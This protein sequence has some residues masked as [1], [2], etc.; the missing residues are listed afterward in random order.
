MGNNYS[1]IPDID[2]NEKAV[3]VCDY[4]TQHSAVIFDQELYLTVFISEVMGNGAPLEANAK[5][6][7]IYRHPCIVKYITSWQLNSKFH[8]AVEEVTPLSRVL[9]KLDFLQISIGLHSILKALDFLHSNRVSHNNVCMSSIYV[10]KEGDWK[11]GGMEY[12]CNYTDLNCDYLNKIENNREYSD[13]VGD[14]RRKD[15]VDLYAFGSLA[16]D[17]LKSITDDVV[18]IFIDFCK[19]NLLNADVTKRPTFKTILE[20][21]F[22]N[23]RFIEI[24]SFLVELPLKSDTEK[25]GF[26]QDLAEKLF[27]FEEEVVASRL[28]GL[29]LS[30]MVFLD[31]TAQVTLLPFLL[32][33]RTDLK[34]KNPHLFSTETFKK[35][36]CH[37]LIEI[38]KVRDR[39]IR[40]YL[41][42]FFPKYMGTFTKEDLQ[43]KIL[44]ELLVGIKDTDDHL[45]SLTLKTLAILVPILGSATVIGGKRAKFF[46]DG[47]PA[48]E[49]T[50]NRELTVDVSNHRVVPLPERPRPDGEEGETSTEDSDNNWEDWDNEE[51]RIIDKN[52]SISDKSI[53]DKS[54][55]DISRLDIKNRSF[56]EEKIEEINFFEDMEPIIDNSNTFLVDKEEISKKLDVIDTEMN[57]EW[58]E[59]DWN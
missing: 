17:V 43:K 41:L 23:H 46:T 4:W 52:E 3:E 56:E 13:P 15:C 36:L 50:K 20:E 12:L 33:P 11:L 42:S 48:R 44:P 25:T 47:R 27:D 57:A 30:R 8:L 7:M 18:S 26:F 55:P 16:I 24:H 19:S 49:Y 32:S 38:F 40:S 35:H 10:T 37:K 58:D 39:E 1:N 31:K 29:L 6:L 22:F 59:E 54:I 51:N 45:V 14:L 28:S 53:A 21:D 2:I 5:H 9:S 34:D